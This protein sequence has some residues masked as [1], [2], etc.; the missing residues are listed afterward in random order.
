MKKLIFTILIIIVLAFVVHWTGIPV[1]T[2]IDMGLDWVFKWT[3]NIIPK[4]TEILPQWGAKVKETVSG[5]AG[6][7]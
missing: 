1:G 4:L 7:L 6:S 2:Y 5:W 3:S